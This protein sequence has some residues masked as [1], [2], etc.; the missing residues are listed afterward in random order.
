[1]TERQ[2]Q[3]AVI[4]LFFEETLSKETPQVELYSFGD[5]PRAILREPYVFIL[6]VGI[7]PD[8]DKDNY[9]NFDMR[10]LHTKWYNDKE[11]TEI[12]H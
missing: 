12:Y 5:I 6:T 9:D 1:M 8:Y 2:R 10:D 4:S 11:R 7:L 3:V